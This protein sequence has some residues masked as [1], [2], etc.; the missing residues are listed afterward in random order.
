MSPEEIGAFLRKYR[1]RLKTQSSS[2]VQGYERIGTQ[3]WLAEECGVTVKTISNLESGRSVVSKE[4]VKL[5]CSKLDVNYNRISQFTNI[6]PEIVKIDFRSQKHISEVEEDPKRLKEC[7][8]MIT[9]DPFKLSCTDDDYARLERINLLFPGEK[10]PF[11]A[12][13]LVK[14]VERGKGWLGYE[15]DFG[16]SYDIDSEKPFRESVMLSQ[17]GLDYL[18]W[19]KFLLMLKNPTSTYLD[20]QIDL[21]FDDHLFKNKFSVSFLVKVSK[22]ELKDLI[23]RFEEK[24]PDSLPCRMHGDA[25]MFRDTIKFTVA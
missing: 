8:L 7:R 3:K 1:E 10:T 11:T 20:F 9:L 23:D 5:V 18:S 4:T 25:Q 19:E 12:L 22:Y 6:H 15:N 14:L 17:D 21:A 13:R 24:K 16:P 2:K